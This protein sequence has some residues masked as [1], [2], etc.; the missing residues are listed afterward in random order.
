MDK[1]IQ[2]ILCFPE[3]S[4]IEGC[5]RAYNQALASHP[6]DK[7]TRPGS[8]LPQGMARCEF[9]HQKQTG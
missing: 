2:I 7:E 1:T 9:N 6:A 8:F 5:Y 3:G 4:V